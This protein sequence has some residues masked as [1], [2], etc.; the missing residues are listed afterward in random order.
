MATTPD[1]QRARYPL[2]AYN[3]KVR[4]GGQAMRFSEVTGLA[5]EYEHVTY[6]HGLTFREGE[7]IAKYR[8]DRYVPITMKR[9]TMRG[10]TELLDWLERRGGRPLEISLCD[11]QGEPVMT[12]RVAKAVAVK[13][14]APGFDASGGDVAIETL[15]VMAAGISI[16]AGG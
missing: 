6:R 3:F 2:M 15:E 11:E 1:E 12:W 8:L 5:R 4:V 9:G 16:G 14:E 10:S 7:D 13:L